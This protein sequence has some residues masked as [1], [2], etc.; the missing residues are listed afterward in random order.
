MLSNDLDSQN[1]I[2]TALRR[3]LA[4]EQRRLIQRDQDIRHLEHSL[5]QLK[6]SMGQELT[7]KSRDCDQ[8]R[9]AYNEL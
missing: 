5:N 3:D 8:L 1:S 2:N 6:E 9:Q 4:E 7:S